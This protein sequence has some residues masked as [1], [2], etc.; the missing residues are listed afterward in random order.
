MVQISEEIVKTAGLNDAQMKSEIAIM[1]F[2]Q[3][4]LTLGQA[5]KLAGLHQIQFQ[6]ELAKRKISVHYDVAEFEK[7]LEN[8]K[9]HLN[10]CHQ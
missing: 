1:L 4:R 7:D 2:Q 3:E 8:V 5:S 9:L 10:A 6:K